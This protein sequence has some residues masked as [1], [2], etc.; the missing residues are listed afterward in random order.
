MPPKNAACA[1]LRKGGNDA[2]RASKL[3][4]SVCGMHIDIEKHAVQV[5]KEIG[6]KW[7]IQDK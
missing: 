2:P 6:D 4:S 5:M 1:V 7:L 3:A